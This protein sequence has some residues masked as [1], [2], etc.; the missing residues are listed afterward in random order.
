MEGFLTP[1]LFCLTLFRVGWIMG[2]GSHT[3][4]PPTVFGTTLNYVALRLLSVPASDP[5]C[6]RARER[7]MEMGG[8][9]GV[10]SWGK[11]W[12]AILNCYKWEG[13]SPICPEIMYVPPSSPSFSVLSLKRF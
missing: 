10:P 7:L 13:L 6:L 4:S 12:L 3:S 5:V 9:E 11:A 2:F 1:F 8:A